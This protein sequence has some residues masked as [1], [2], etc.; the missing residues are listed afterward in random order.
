MQRGA[1]RVAARLIFVLV[2]G[3]HENSYTKGPTLTIRDLTC[4]CLVLLLSR[5]S[6]SDTPVYYTYTYKGREYDPLVLFILLFTLLSTIVLC[7]KPSDNAL[8]VILLL[9]SLNENDLLCSFKYLLRKYSS[10]IK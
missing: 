1:T 3:S 7:E 9:F 8:K 5:Y 10:T 4:R 6:F 2:L